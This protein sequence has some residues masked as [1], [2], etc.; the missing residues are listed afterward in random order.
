M[1]ERFEKFLNDDSADMEGV[2]MDGDMM[3]ED[4]TGEEDDEEDDEEDKDVSFDEAEFEK[5]MREM[6]GLPPDQDANI[7]SKLADNGEE[8][9]WKV[10]NQVET[11]LREAGVI[12]C[13]EQPHI[14][15]LNEGEESDEK[16]TDVDEDGEVDIDFNLAKNLLES[17]K[18]QGGMAGPGGNLLASMGI[19]LPRD[20]DGRAEQGEGKGEGKE[21][22]G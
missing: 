18:S 9:I 12:E 8:E 1:V 10:M 14:K 7:T 21:R 22:L 19:A 16:T 2:D 13:P 15:G 17:F 4:D 3:G 20:E 11:E 6:M 5:M